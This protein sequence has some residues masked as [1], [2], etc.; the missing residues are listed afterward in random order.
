MLGFLN[1]DLIPFELLS[2]SV[3]IH[4]ELTVSEGGAIVHPDCC[5][6]VFA[7]PHQSGDRMSLKNLCK[8]Q[9]LR[10]EAGVASSW[11]PSSSP[12]PSSPGIFYNI[13]NTLQSGMLVL[14][15]IAFLFISRDCSQDLMKLS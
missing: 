6:Q 8:G 15:V 10:S 1:L 5:H 12:V 4:R 14:P 11:S 3:G 13:E 7:S 9:T 2:P